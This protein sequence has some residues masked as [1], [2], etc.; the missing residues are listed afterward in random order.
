MCREPPQDR[1]QRGEP[2]E[3]D[4]REA[5]LGS[6]H[7][8]G[9]DLNHALLSMAYLEGADLAGAL[10]SR[11]TFGNRNLS[12]VIA[13]PTIGIDTNYR[14]KGKI[15]EAFLRAA[16]CQKALSSSP[17]SLTTN[18]IGFYSCF[19]RYSTKASPTASA[20]ACRTKACAAGLLHTTFKAAGNSTSRSTK[21]YPPARQVAVDPVAALHGE[22]VGKDGN[23]QGPQAARRATNGASCFLFGSRPF[24][25]LRD[26]ECFDADN[27]KDSAREIREYLNPGFSHWKNHDSYQEAFERRMSDR[28][29]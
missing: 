12:G 29:S 4:L 14:S 23:R 25:T 9:A 22:R 15:P 3:A 24:A 26:W 10:V 2:R 8:G 1:P 5:N 27:G 13:P 19:I 16:A 6:A 21:P 7:L 11:T 18:P 28:K 17:K 20:P